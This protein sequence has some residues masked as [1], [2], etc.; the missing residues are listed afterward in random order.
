L[1][2]A[3]DGQTRIGSSNTRESTATSADVARVEV[4]IGPGSSRSVVVEEKN[5]DSASEEENAG[6]DEAQ[7]P[8]DS[9]DV[10]M[11]GEES[12]EDCWHDEEG[13]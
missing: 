10:V 3:E 13:D 12:V 8:R 2:R 1:R 7:S 9:L 5:G 11:I 6:N 4:A